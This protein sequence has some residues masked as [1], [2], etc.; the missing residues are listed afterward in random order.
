MAD[1]RRT[2]I[3]EIVKKEL[4]GPDLIDLPGK[5]QDNG[6][7][8]LTSGSPLNRYIA[9]ILFPQKTVEDIVVDEETLDQKEND[10]EILKN[11]FSKFCNVYKYSIEPIK[12]EQNGFI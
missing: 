1:T 10:T 5:I 11:I 4:I 12:K 3:I 2:Q 6:E 7:E 9:G 8:I